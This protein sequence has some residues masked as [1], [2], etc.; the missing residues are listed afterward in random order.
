MEEKRKKSRVSFYIGLV[1]ALLISF[2]AG[3]VM[4]LSLAAEYLA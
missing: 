1:I 4:G 3:L 2:A